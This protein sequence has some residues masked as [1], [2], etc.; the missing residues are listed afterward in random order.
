[1]KNR[2]VE[3][4][5]G[6]DRRNLL[7]LY[8]SLIIL[9]VIFYLNINESI[10]SNKIEQNHGTILKL[11]KALKSNKILEKK[12]LKLKKE[13]KGI[14]KNIFALQEDI[15]YLKILIST[16]LM[17]LNDKKFIGFLKTILDISVENGLNSSYS[18][19][20]EKDKLIQYTIFLNGNFEKERYRDF[21]KFIQ[22]IEKLKV[23]KTINQSTISDVNG[24]LNYKII[25]N[26]WGIE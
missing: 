17:S 24:I 4:I 1:M 20:K 18:I 14:Q 6:L 19:S 5:N 7:M 16:S 15:K 25:I 23:I 26:F 21:V 9:A 12:I 11:K 3:Y 22:E 10:F 13:Y 8:M 2:I